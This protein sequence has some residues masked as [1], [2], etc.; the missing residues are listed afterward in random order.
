M[1]YLF[2]G[3]WLGHH[4]RLKYRGETFRHDLKD[5]DQGIPEKGNTVNHHK[6]SP[7]LERRVKVLK[8]PFF[9][10]QEDKI[11]L[12]HVV[13]HDTWHARYMPHNNILLRQ[14]DKRPDLGIR[15]NCFSDGNLSPKKWL[16]T[17][18]VISTSNFKLVIDHFHGDKAYDIRFC[19]YV[20]L[21]YMFSLCCPLCGLRFHYAGN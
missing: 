8:A 5:T 19:M 11:R 7:S 1:L 15:E 2:V 18:S 9:I 20:V 3:H 4:W 12:N 13:S 17:T 6:Q 21:I 10:S 16:R 14:K